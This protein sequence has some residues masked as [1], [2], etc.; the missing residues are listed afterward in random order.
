[1]SSPSSLS[2]LSNTPMEAFCVLEFQSTS[3]ESPPPPPE[4]TDDEDSFFDL[5]LKS[6]DIRSTESP[7]DVFRRGNGYVN[8]R[9][10]C[11]VTLVRSTPKF[12]V[13]M[14]GF[15][16]SVKCERSESNG[17]TKRSPLI[18]SPRSPKV[19]CRDEKTLGT[20]RVARANSLRSQ[21][22]KETSDYENSPEKSSRG[23]IPKYLKL[24]RPLYLMVWRRQHEKK[25]PTESSTPFASPANI[26][27]KR[28]SDGSRIGSFKIAARRLGKS[29]SASTAVGM[30]P[31]PARRRDDSL[32]ERLDG[33]QNAVL[34][35]KRSYSSSS[36]KEFS[37]IYQSS[38][39][40]SKSS[41]EESK[42]CSI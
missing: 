29:R 20:C 36:S 22:L 2:T 40:H 32:L 16:K 35:C 38:V 7:G 3:P 11:K 37:N 5:V 28:I 41:Y 27:P 34:Y 42:R 13:F 8:S 25:K 17:E 39:D 21:L 1:M 33:I 24:I 4:Q 14:L 12:R 6:P 18:H 9:P 31:Q 19:T 30:S 15:G 23:L 26:S 10:L